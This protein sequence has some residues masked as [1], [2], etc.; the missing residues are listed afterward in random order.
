MKAGDIIKKL[1][2]EN[3]YTQTEL[4]EKLG[5]KLSTLQKYENSTIENF[6]VV[7]I[8]KLCEVFDIPPYL[9]IYPDHIN[10]PVDAVISEVYNN[11]EARV[12]TGLLLSLKPDGKRRVL[13][14]IKDIASV[15]KYQLNEDY[16]NFYYYNFFLENVF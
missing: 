11:K 7:T 13:E 4:A 2:I 10:L 3:K 8:R 12:I 16:K 1:R 9:L 15:E 6:K 5:I 14:Y